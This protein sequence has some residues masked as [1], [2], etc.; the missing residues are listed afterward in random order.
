MNDPSSRSPVFFPDFLLVRLDDRLLH[1]Q[2]VLGWGEHLTPRGYL[3]V[4]GAAEMKEV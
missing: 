2:V 1:G 3:I 4:E